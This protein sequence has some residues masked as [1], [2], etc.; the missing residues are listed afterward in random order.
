MRSLALTLRADC[1]FEDFSFIVLPMA[2]CR[3]LYKALSSQLP[4]YYYESGSK[5]AISSRVLS[6]LSVSGHFGLKGQMRSMTARESEREREREREK[7]KKRER[8][9]IQACLS[10]STAITNRKP[11]A[12]FHCRWII[13]VYL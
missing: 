4:N 5:V 1:T 11:L 13:A 6:K 2:V 10:E 12:I 9:R 7:Q 8:E 3:Q